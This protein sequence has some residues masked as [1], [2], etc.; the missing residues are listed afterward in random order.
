MKRKKLNVC[1][2][3]SGVRSLRG[4]A[5]FLIVYSIIGLIIAII[6]IANLSESIHYSHQYGYKQDDSGSYA[7]IAFGVSS[8]L[9]GCIFAPVLRGLATI[10]ETA[11]IKKHLIL[12]DYEIIGSD[13][14]AV[15]TSHE[16]ADMKDDNIDDDTR[17]ATFHDSNK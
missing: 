2:D 17:S 12:M 5:T 13:K 11:L 6:G 10:A 4:W 15:A 9:S 16:L 8:I 1:Y 7:L 3:G 14:S